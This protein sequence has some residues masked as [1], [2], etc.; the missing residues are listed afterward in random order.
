MQQ[1]GHSAYVGSYVSRMGSAHYCRA[2]IAATGANFSASGRL[3]LI[4]NCA[5][6]TATV[7]C[8]TVP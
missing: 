8:W 2:S 6:D 4:R 7:R 5:V 1:R 3:A